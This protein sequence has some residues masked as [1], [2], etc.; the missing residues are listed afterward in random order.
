MPYVTITASDTLSAER[1]KNL[2]AKASTAVVE[3]IGA[4]L[5]SVRVLLHSLAT[6]DYLDGGQYGRPA[7]MLEVALIAGRTEAQKAA[8]I[9]A[10]SRASSEATGVSEDDVRVRLYDIPT[11]DMGMAG[12][13][14][15]KQA[16]R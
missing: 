3:S 5:A 6:D 11:T 4:P 13:I 9:A 10:L 16:G 2:L 12:G 8:L 1:K 14:T 7:L 15:A